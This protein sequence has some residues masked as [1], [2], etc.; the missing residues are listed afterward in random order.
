MRRLLVICGLALLVS[1]CDSPVSPAPSDL[2][3][4]WARAFSIPGASLV[5][6]LDSSGNGS[7]TYSIEA[8]RSGVLQVSGTATTS[9]VTLVIRYDYG[10]ALT[11]TGALTDANHL[12]GSFASTNETATFTRR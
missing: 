1:T 12:V 7:G 11:F 9:L 3:G 5:L 2:A 10:A 4:T 6:T 8:G